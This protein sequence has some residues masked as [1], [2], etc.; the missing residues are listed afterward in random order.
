MFSGIKPTGAFPLC[1]ASL[2]NAPAAAAEHTKA[3]QQ[4]YDQFLC[5]PQPEGEEGRIRE[6]TNQISQKIRIRPTRHE[7]ASLQEQI[8]CGTYKPDCRE[9]AARMLLMDF[10]EV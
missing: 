4:V 1:G 8:K 3:G 2:Y 10:Q 7:I 6:M 9:I 5:S